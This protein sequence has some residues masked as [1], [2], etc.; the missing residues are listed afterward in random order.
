MVSVPIKGVTLRWARMAMRMSTRELARAVNVKPEK[1][2]KFESED[3]RPTLIQLEKIAKKLDRTPAFFF[4]DPPK[5]EAHPKTI[6]FRGKDSAPLESKL[7]REI[8]RAMRCREVVIDLD[9]TPVLPALVGEITRNNA[10]HRAKELRHKLDLENDFVPPQADNSKVF[11]FWRNVLEHHGFLVF[12]T[13]GIEIDQYRGLSIEFSEL[14]IILVNSADDN[15]AKAFTLFHEV[16]HLCNR[17][18]GICAAEL[19]NEQEILANNFASQFLVPQ[20]ALD[21]VLSQMPDT[22]A[23]EMTSRISKHFRV[24]L[25]AAATRLLDM[26]AITRDDWLRIREFVQKSWQEKH[27]KLKKSKGGPARWS[28]R[29]SHLGSNY[30]GTIAQAIE[31]G[32]ISLLDASYFTGERIPILERMIDEYN[33]VGVS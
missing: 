11:K 22:S 19:G 29:F 4:L 12:Q 18:S 8:H 33:R 23:M 31:D 32:R 20:A 27:Q 25:L 10:A 17:T 13:P 30:V 2:D 1:I 24:S 6:D 28:T 26:G 9:G 21:S 7:T 14:P 5:N 16:A 15:S 3:A